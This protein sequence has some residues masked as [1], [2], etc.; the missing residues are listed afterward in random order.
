MQ[1]RV[2]DQNE[3]L[4][5]GRGL[6]KNLQREQ[7]GVKMLL[8]RAVS[9]DAFVRAAAAHQMGL[10]DQRDMAKCS[11]TLFR[12]L[13][14]KDNPV[15]VSALQTLCEL[16][17][18]SLGHHKDEFQDNLFKVLLALLED[19]DFSIR[20]WSIRLMQ[21]VEPQ[22]AITSESK[23]GALEKIYQL[24]DDEETLVRVLCIEVVICQRP[25]KVASNIY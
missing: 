20:E 18:R 19:A 9:A 22:F 8:D 6:G 3:C 5:V 21:H 16:D 11:D 17:M 12:M 7:P 4:F 15:R 13:Y 14:D 10:L 24:V 1:P 23:G 25:T 2:V